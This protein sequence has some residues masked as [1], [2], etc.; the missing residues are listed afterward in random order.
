MADRYCVVG[1]AFITNGAV[2]TCAEA[3]RV[4]AAGDTTLNLVDAGGG[5]TFTITLA[6]GCTG[7][8]TSG[9]ST[10]T[11]SPKSLVAG[12]NTI[13]AAGTGTATL[14][15]TL[16]VGGNLN[17]VNSWSASSGGVSGASVPTSS[18]N[19][20]FDA[21][22]YTA[23]SQ[24]LTV[25][26]TANCLDM[27][28]T[29]ATNTPT[30]AFNAQLNLYGNITFIAAMAT[31]A[32]GGFIEIRASLTLTTNGLSIAAFIDMNSGVYTL[33]LADN[34]T[35]NYI[36]LQNGTLDTANHNITFTGGTFLHSST[37]AVTLTPGS[38]TFS[39]SGSNGVNFSGAGAVTVTANTA[40]FTLTGTCQFNGGSADWNGASINL[41]GTSHTVSGSFTCNVLT[42]NG[43]A[44]K[45]DTVTFTSG[46][47]ITCTTFA[48]IGNSATNRLLV[49]SSTLGT[50]F[51]VTATNWTGTTACDIMDCTATNAVDLSGAATYTGDCGGNTNITFTTAAAQISAAN[52]N[53]S[54][55]A[56]WQ[57][58]VGTDR[59]PLPQDDWTASHNITLDM[60]R[61]GKSITFTGTPTV[62]T[63]SHCYVFGALTCIAGMTL[64]ADWNRGFYF[65]GRGSYSV[66]SAGK[67]LGTFI[68]YAPGGTYIL[69]DAIAVQVNMLAVY[70]GT[71][72]TNGQNAL[73]EFFASTG[74]ATR[75]VILGA[76]TITATRTGT[77]IKVNLV[78]TGLTFTAGTSTIILTNSTANAQEFRGGGLTY[79]NVTIQG[80]GAYA[81]TISGSNT[82]NTLTIDRSEAAKTLT[83]TDGTTQTVTNF[84]CTPIGTTTVTLNGTST[85]GWALNKLGVGKIG[86]LDYLVISYSTANPGNV[87]YAGPN[88]TDVTGNTGWIFNTK[89][90]ESF[91]GLSFAKVNI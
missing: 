20:Y 89:P 38:S 57:D 77:D 40:T 32:S 28:W 58:G 49:Q 6:S 7:T 70:N 2:I 46:T 24:V 56:T 85:A 44:T 5:G 66:T 88:S 1:Q 42:R 35:V 50:A 61:A 78:S 71:L 17:T 59:V 75:S 72:N 76:S 82:F 87:W 23:G 37:N 14:N 45:T 60:P 67:G 22:S 54:T 30:L 16:G 13:T 11:D 83:F 84:V 15:L 81:L 64:N 63:T 25:D 73:T 41:N 48:M 27:D 53:A 31:S 80:A 43:T 29:G 39:F 55:L 34:L 12:A 65:Y 52:G 10:I 21:N 74:T 62:I 9:T 8:I 36:N 4:A 47:T 33:T 19:V 68:V 79:N 3:G 90:L 26:A 86:N 51:T 69:Q 91:M 18:D